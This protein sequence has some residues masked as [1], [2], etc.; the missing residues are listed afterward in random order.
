MKR[1]QIL[2]LAFSATACGIWQGKKSRDP[3]PPKSE[4]P[5]SEDKNPA[6]AGTTK[7]GTDESGNPVD[8]IAPA[9]NPDSSTP[10]NVA[11]NSQT[12]AEPVPEPAPETGGK[13]SPTPEPL[14]G[15]G[16]ETAPTQPTP[17]SP[18]E[19]LAT[20][21]SIQLK[22]V[23]A[24]CVGCHAEAKRWNRFV[25]LKDISKIITYPSQGT[26]P[27]SISDESKRK[28]IIVAG[29]P[30]QSM[31]LQSI[32]SGDMPPGTPEDKIAAKN[33]EI[34]RQ[35][36]RSLAKSPEDRCLDDEPRD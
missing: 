20:T 2:I 17:P 14:P 27:I 16:S 13:P 8:P 35:W 11:E 6:L 10:A 31:I 29:C 24:S 15:T 25:G 9:N 32:A 36:I 21:E 3:G 34:V 19:W 22:L 28:D 1:L 7:P 23:N 4:A 26:T 12:E 33:V 5:R 30:E 18:E